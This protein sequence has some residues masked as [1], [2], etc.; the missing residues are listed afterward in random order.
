[1]LKSFESAINL[2]K[3]YDFTKKM[4]ESEVQMAPL[5]VVGIIIP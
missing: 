1:M 3:T 4:G 2:L 5:G